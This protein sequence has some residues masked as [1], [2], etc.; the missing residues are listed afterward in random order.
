MKIFGYTVVNNKTKSIR[1]LFPLIV[2]LVILNGCGDRA[3]RTY[4]RGL[5]LARQ[6]KYEQAEAE[7]R[8]LIRVDPENARAHNALGQIYRAQN[9]YNKAI[10]ELTLSVEMNNTDPE[11]PYNLGCLY[12]DL[13]DLQ[14]AADYFHKAIEIDPDFAPALYRLGAIYSDRG[15][16]VKAEKYFREFLAKNPER[17]AP[18][19][20]NLGVILWKSGRREEAM[21]EFKTALDEE[22]D[23]P[24]ALYNYGVASLSVNN[25][26]RDGIKAILSYLKARP[27]AREGPEL[28][29][30]LLRTGVVDASEAGVFSRDDYLNR[31]KE[32][33]G[34]GQYRAAAKEYHRA[35]RL[36]PDS[37]RAHY[38][39]GVIYDQYL[40]DKAN[41]IHHY[42]IFLAG[43]K[44]SP[45]AAE[46]IARLKEIRQEIDMEALA[47]EG[48]IATPSP[49]VAPTTATPDGIVPLEKTAEDFLRQGQEWSDKGDAEKAREA[50]YQAIE[51]SPEN[52]QAYLGIGRAYIALG[53]Y[54][55]AVKSL[56]KVRNLDKNVPIKDLLIQTYLR[57]GA[58]ALSSKRFKESMDYYE[59]AREE[60]GV[61]QAE[62]GLWKVYHAYFRDR[63]Q[64]GDYKSAASYLRACLKLKPDVADDHLALGDL[65]VNKLGDRRQGNRE[66]A[67]Y[68]ELSPRGKDADRIREIIKTTHTNAKSTT[69]KIVTPQS[70]KYSAIEYYNRGT[71]FQ[72][73]GEYESARKEYL[74]AINLKPDF[75]Q[76]YYNLGVLY[77]KNNEQD[78]ALNAYKR[79]AA[80]NPNFPRAQLAIFNLYYYHYKMKNLARPYAE[81]YIRLAPGT[82]QAEELSKWLKK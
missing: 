43:N 38:R 82:K 55:N 16:P 7:I 29:R 61:A 46:I 14:K 47:A 21:I 42:E 28:K 6:K 24:A 4:K 17:T 15:E 75:Y 39:L 26:D 10:E 71:A 58:G 37:S 65:Y 79:A 2:L 1:N 41:A 78:K 53:E 76:A 3:E 50:Y 9:L 52:P 8:R 44:Q 32:F 59:K 27:H 30:I 11:L 12:R 23:L 60:G 25:K 33:E 74:Q 63:Y 45:H 51:L 13:E 70:E 57:L 18:G 73:K 69:K 40:E 19:H 72:S 77:N 35:L 22:S 67:K 20:N 34:V 54:E 64:T 36:A 80:I 48:L 81:N 31:G 66:Y 49:Q 5:K 68:L 62:E 56:L